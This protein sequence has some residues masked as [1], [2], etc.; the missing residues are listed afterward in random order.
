MKAASELSDSGVIGY[1]VSFNDNTVF[2]QSRDMVGRVCRV[3]PLV[4]HV[5]HAP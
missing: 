2:C 3:S 5:L 4:Q 1:D